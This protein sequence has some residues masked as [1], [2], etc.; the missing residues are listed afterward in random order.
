M[1]HPIGKNAQSD[2]N[3][4]QWA[5]ALEAIHT[6]ASR[7]MAKPRYWGVAYPLA[8]TSLCVASEEYFMKHWSVLCDFS[9][10]KLKASTFFNP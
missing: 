9:F 2:V 4:P 8:V 5:H 3:H 1:L 6:K 10:T 7:M